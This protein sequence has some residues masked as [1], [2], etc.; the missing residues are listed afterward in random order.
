MVYCQ[1]KSMKYTNT[2][3]CSF[4]TTDTARNGKQ[5]CCLMSFFFKLGAC[6]LQ[7]MVCVVTLMQYQARK[8]TFLFCSVPQ[9]WRLT[10]KKGD[11]FVLFCK[12]GVF[13]RFRFLFV[14]PHTPLGTE[15]LSQ[16]R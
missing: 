3:K 14:E 5:W 2:L 9:E 8:V 7:R 12:N 16:F 10:A 15:N 6:S 1:L 11:I 13:N 4:H